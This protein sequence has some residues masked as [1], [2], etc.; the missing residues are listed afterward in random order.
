[1]SIK[2]FEQMIDNYRDGTSHGFILSFN[3]YDYVSSDCQIMLDQYLTQSLIKNRDVILT[4]SRD[5]GFSFP[6]QSMKYWVLEFI[7]SDQNEDEIGNDIL[8][9]L[10]STGNIEA[11]SEDRDLPNDPN[12]A[13]PLIDR[14]LRESE[15]ILIIIQDIELILP[16]QDLGT[17]SNSDRTLLAIMRKWARDFSIEANNN[18]IV[19]TTNN[20]ASIHSELKSASNRYESIVIGLPDYE[21]RFRFLVD[22]LSK[23]GEKID[24]NGLTIEGIAS[25]T[26]GLNLIQ[27]ENILL[28][29]KRLGKIQE[30]FIWDRKTAIIK[31]EFGDLLEVINPSLG[32]N[33]IGGLNHIKKFFQNSVITPIKKGNTNRV[34]MGV[35]MTGPAGTG[36]SIM[37]IAVAKETGIN[38][39]NLRIGGNIASK[40]QGEGE[41]NLQKALT[42]IES[43]SPSIVF[44]DEIDQTVSRGNGNNQQDSRIFQR[45]LEFMSDTSHRGKIVFLGATNRPDL[46]DAA[47]KRPGRFDKKIPFL[48][49]DK[50]EREAIFKVMVKRYA[51]I[52][53]SDIGIDL[54]ENTKNQTGAEIEGIVIKSIELIE[55]EN[56]DINEALYQASLRLSPS[57]SDIEFMTKLALIETNDKDLLPPN[58]RDRLDDKP[59]LEKEIKSFERKSRDI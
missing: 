47:L 48:M 20:L 55:D 35:L 37:A 28:R 56:L 27:I 12:E 7:S 14:L 1:M 25:L 33:D 8:A 53:L 38:S 16:D 39:L 44:I 51:D 6:L 19:F 52:N 3:I 42:A 50:T 24:I 36:K 29:A 22:K 32:F 23:M 15:N 34:P 46:L 26:S 9:A 2:W 57:T 5:K 45:L 18:L 58:Y 49:P 21:E 11:N 41:R 43:L 17:M 40:W 31:S 10:Q 54:L 30:K 13:I 59:S 4:Y